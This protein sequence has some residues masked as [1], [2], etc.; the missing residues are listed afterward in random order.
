VL[1]FER[2]KGVRRRAKGERRRDAKGERASL[3]RVLL[4]HAI[5]RPTDRWTRERSAAAVMMIPIPKRGLLKRVAGDDAARRVPDVTEVIVTAKTDQLLEPLPEAGSYL[6][7]VFARA[8]TAADAE[9]AV[10]DAHAALAFE[11]ESPIPV[12]S[13]TAEA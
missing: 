8:D 10:R 9:R 11:I 12:R 4:E 2:A 7:F 1:E 3:E 5:G 6:G 13:V